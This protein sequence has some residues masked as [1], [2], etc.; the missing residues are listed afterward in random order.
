MIAV[1]NDG[2]F[3][4]LKLFNR[5]SINSVTIYRPNESK[6]Y[7]FYGN[8]NN[9]ISAKGGLPYYRTGGAKSTELEAILNINKILR[10]F[11][12]AFTYGTP[13]SIVG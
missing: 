5:L 7:V 10:S 11:K 12:G 6:I 13:R 3:F 2:R 1:L 4:Q 9:S 8:G